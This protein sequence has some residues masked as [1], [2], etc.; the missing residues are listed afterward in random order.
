MNQVLVF[1]EPGDKGPS[2]LVALDSLAANKTMP[3]SVLFG[4]RVGERSQNC[5]IRVRTAT[6]ELNSIPMPSDEATR[7]GLIA[8]RTGEAPSIIM[9]YTGH[10]GVTIRHIENDVEVGGH[11]DGVES[12]EKE[13]VD[14]GG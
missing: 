2:K 7:R 10:I 9:R 8:M 6:G 14:M 13:D 3:L 4:L 11:H 5:Y 12:N 1:D